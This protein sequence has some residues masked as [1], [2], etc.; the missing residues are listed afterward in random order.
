M[1]SYYTKRI[2]ILYDI[3][4][5]HDLHIVDEIF[6]NVAHMLLGLHG[7]KIEDVKNIVSHPQVVPL[8]NFSGR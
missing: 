4:V 1:E 2:R 8:K 7:S 5:H 6:L 3:M